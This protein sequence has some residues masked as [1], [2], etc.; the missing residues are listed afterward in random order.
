MH[1]RIQSQEV[2]RRLLHL[3]PGLFFYVFYFC[4]Q[5]DPLEKWSLWV[6]TGTCGAGAVGSLHFARFFRRPEE[7]GWP[8][9]VLSYLAV[10]L[11]L[12]WLFPDRTEIAGTV[13]SII[14]FGDGLATLVGMLLVGPRL[15]WN[16]EKSWAGSGAFVAGSLLFGVFAFWLQSQPPVSVGASFACV[17]PAVLLG[18]IAESLPSRINDNLRVGVVAATA[19]LAAQAALGIA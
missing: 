8:V 12:V 4:P 5:A 11:L 17:A 14:A 10:V 3:V 16:P 2:K 9:S 18:A 15:P 19:I 13:V 1:A 7:H 6:V